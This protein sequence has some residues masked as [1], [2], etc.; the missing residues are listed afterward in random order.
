M[1]NYF[2]KIILF[3]FLPAISFAQLEKVI[4]ETYYV[5][6]SIDATDTDGGHLSKGS[7]TYRIYV[8]LKP[9][10][11]LRKIYGDANHALKIK[12]DSVFF[13]N[14]DRGQSFGKDFSKSHYG[15]NTV[16]V[17]TWL[18]LGQVSKLGAK[19]YFGI[20][21]NQDTDGSFVGGANNDGGSLSQP[22]GLLNNSNSIIGI[23]LT[24]ADGIDTMTAIPTSWANYGIIDLISGEDSTI[25]GSVK[26]GNE[27]VSYNAGIQCSGVTGVIPDSNQILVAQL[28]TKGALSFE[29]NIEVEEPNGSNTKIVKYVADD[30]IL[31]SDE[32]W[33]RYLTY[34]YILK[35]GC[36]D[37]DYLEYKTDRDC[38]SQDSCKTL[39]VFGCTDTMACNFD[40]NAN[41]NIQT[42]CCYVGYCADRDISLVCPNLK[43]NMPEFEVYPNPAK[44]EISVRLVD[45][46]ITTTNTNMVLSVYNTLG[47]KIFDKQISGITNSIFET[48]D[49]SSL[50]PGIYLIRVSD[51]INF[52][53][54]YFIKE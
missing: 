22:A 34:P 13:N 5:S 4:V 23:P 33:D 30:S 11:K 18:T 41:Y 45:E 14:I 53:N 21:K 31:L 3:L 51:Q 20:L 48:I 2:I 46:N 10:S 28:T 36:P 47:Q 26:A 40:I 44:T 38:D 42:L 12:S 27:F 1:K 9:G 35:C 24:I 49:I 7:I 25:F 29:L 43:L 6:D 16:A 50:T 39:I 15:S 52:Y 19:T 54:K 8:D 37:P 17:D 32:K